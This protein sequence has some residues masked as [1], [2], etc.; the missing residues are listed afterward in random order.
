MALSTQWTLERVRNEGKSGNGAE[1]T[2]GKPAIVIMP[3]SQFWL[4]GPAHE[5]NLLLHC[6]KD[7]IRLKFRKWRADGPSW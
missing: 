6:N 7:Q 5:T 1:I 2:G 4:T 3:G